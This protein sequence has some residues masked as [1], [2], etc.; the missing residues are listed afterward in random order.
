MT[1][2]GDGLGGLKDLN[3]L[4]PGGI[5]KNPRGSDEEDPVQNNG[6]LGYGL[7]KEPKGSEKDE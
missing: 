1:G 2:S 5:F 3:P 4:N 6:W 7:Y